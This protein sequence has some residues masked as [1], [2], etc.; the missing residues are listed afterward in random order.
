MNKLEKLYFSAL[1]AAA[2]EQRD[3]A[4]KLNPISRGSVRYKAATAF[5]KGISKGRLPWDA[6]EHEPDILEGMARAVFSSDW[7]N[8]QEE[9]GRSF[10]GVDIYDAAPKTSSA[11]KKWAR[12]QAARIL[13]M[14]KKLPSLTKLFELVQKGG[15]KR[16]AE[17][18]GAALGLQISGHGV[19]FTDDMPREAARMFEKTFRLPH[20]E[21][22]Y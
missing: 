19:S 3:K 14:N 12:V 16:D 4:G 8:R 2:K 1:K 21:F 20:S 17:S 6:G 10:S 5:E 13:Q 9:R 7:A 18:F 22:F 15:F 11:A